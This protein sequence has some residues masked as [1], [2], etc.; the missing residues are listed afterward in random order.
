[1]KNLFLFSILIGYI[2]SCQCVEYEMKKILSSSRKEAA[3]NNT[4]EY[5]YREGQ[6]SMEI[7]LSLETKLNAGNEYS[8]LNKQRIVKEMP[9]MLIHGYGNEA[10]LMFM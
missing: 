6:M 3:D 10:E 1:M 4:E 2:L 7:E 9:E 8:K 5:Y